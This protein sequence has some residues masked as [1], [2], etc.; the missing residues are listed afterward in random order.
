M[1]ND[2]Q[3]IRR[4]VT[5]KD[6]AKRANTSANTVSKVLRNHPQVSKEK[7]LE[8]LALAD[9]MGYVPNNAARTLRQRK[10]R[11]IGMV[12]GDNSNPYF[13]ESI[14]AAQQKL[15]LYDYRLITFNNFENVEDEV[16]FIRDMCSLYVAGVLLSP[17]MGNSESGNLLKRFNIP[18][19]FMNR[20]PEETK[21][22][23]VVANDER[24]AY[25]ATKHLVEMQKGPVA[26]INFYKDFITARRRF[27]GY[28]QALHQ[29]NI[30]FRGD[31]VI[32]GCT[33]MSDGYHA[34]KQLMVKLKPPYS[35]VCYSD[36]IAMGAMLAA[37]EGRL[38]I[39]ED[40]AIIG[41]DDSDV[42]LN[43]SFGLSSVRLPVIDISEQAVNILMESIKERQFNRRS[44]K[45]QQIILEP[46]L[47]VRHSTNSS[48]QM[49]GNFLG[50]HRKY[51]PLFEPSL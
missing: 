30:A 29:C 38:R 47:I 26:L 9:E 49:A 16:Q 18:F 39:P 37:R 50:D 4:P 34:M 31:L 5:M 25:L 27:Q 22:C 11:L 24:A 10:S 28:E 2:E 32:D 1:M 13:A 19:V 46:K 6:I 3:P 42:L 43:N 48:K 15:K 35:I 44:G 23:F 14:K 12:V 8:I 7:R 51:A 21:A 33:N 20:I 36:Y 41:I 17:A 40:V 45:V